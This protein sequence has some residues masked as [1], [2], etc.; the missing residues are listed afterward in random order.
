M[1]NDTKG[2]RQ[3]TNQFL[4]VV[5]KIQ[6]ALNSKGYSTMR[7]LGKFFRSLD[8]F[9]QDKRLDK[10]EFAIGLRE[11]GVSLTRG[12]VDSL[13]AWMDTNRD[14]FVDFEEFMLVMRVRGKFDIK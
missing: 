8:S 10:E 11:I 13:M 5:Y 12:E 4:R 7:G 3:L 2:K 6:V 14:G 1:D 9:D